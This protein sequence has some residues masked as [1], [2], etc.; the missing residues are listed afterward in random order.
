MGIDK[1]LRNDLFVSALTQDSCCER[2]FN[3][4]EA[5]EK[6]YL[7]S[8]GN[9]EEFWGRA[10]QE[11]QWYKPY[12]KVLDDS[13]KP[14]Y[15]WFVGGELNTCYNAVDYHVETGRGEQLALI[16]DS[17]VTNTIEK[18]TYRELLDLVSRCA[19]G[20]RSLGVIKGDRVI[21]YMPMIPEA[22][23][24]MLACA[25]IG[26][27][28][29]V[30]FGGFAPN[31]LAIRIDDAKPK[32][33]ISASG[34]IEGKKLIEYKPLVD[35]A[36]EMA[37]HKPERCIIYQ[38]K[39]ARATMHPGRDMEWEAVMADA[40]PVDCLP[41]SSTDPLYILYTS[42]TTG[43]P[44]GVVRD[45]GG[46]A[47]A[48]KWSMRNI[49]GVEPGDVF[50]AAS[51]VGWVVGHSYI[52]YAPLFHGCTTIVYEGKPVGTPDAGAFWRVISDHKV[53]VFFTAPTAI[54]AIKKE[55]PKGEFLKK[56]NLAHLKYLFL[57]GERLDP[58]TYYWASELIDKPVIDHWWQTETGWAIAA[59]CM[60]LEPL[61]IKAGS[62]TKPVPGYGIEILDDNGKKVSRGTEGIVAIRLP[63]PPGTLLT[64]W[65]DDTKFLTS[66]LQMFDGCYFTGD[67]GY[68]DQD[69][70]LYVMGRVD[71]VI[72]V[73]GHRLSTGEM[74]EVLSKHPDVA[75]CAVV[76]RKDDFKGQ[77]PL[78]FVVLKSQVKKD[79][80]L[81]V[82]ELVQMVRDQIGAIASFKEA[83]VV[84]RLPKTR[85][86]KILR[87]SMRKIADREPYSI[88]PTIDDPAILT[89][90]DE[91]M[92]RVRSAF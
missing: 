64:L 34:S 52:V 42:G 55:D 10:A 83:V 76:G 82:G 61:P 27:I 84:K 53:R 6:E 21:L 87:G 11:I 7:K 44:K 88:P 91:L 13:Q 69:G 86:G 60:G 4:S 47:V 31:E 14:F 29:S 50:W 20:L 26:A 39:F 25:R 59:N 23:I 40:S 92:K 56:Y 2:K 19:G 79:P 33:V 45:N 3:M 72:N 58:D 16:Y 85:S 49:Y 70:Y 75:E 80:N 89:E 43:L 63:L 24:A 71:D 65:E 78:G 66:Y 67:G 57:A 8:I 68:F 81:I 41:V 37:D 15:R 1:P 30:V 51:D 90:I 54:R 35:K 32:I 77:L 73:A 46:H 28:H 9:P 22:L 62:P 17:P 74:E 36:I 5:Y 12:H 48:L 18:F 38:R